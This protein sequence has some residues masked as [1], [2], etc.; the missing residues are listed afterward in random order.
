MI[1]REQRLMHP[2]A[3]FQ[4][5]REGRSGPRPWDLQVQVTGR[6]GNRPRP[7]PVALGGPGLGPLVRMRADHRRQQASISA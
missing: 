4:Q 7:V 2:S 6:G 5:G 3:A 1:H